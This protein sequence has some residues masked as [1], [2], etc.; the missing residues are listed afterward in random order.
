MRD[1]GRVISADSLEQQAVHRVRDRGRVT[2][3]DSLEQRAV[4]RQSERQ[5]E[6]DICRQLRTAGC[7]QTE[8]G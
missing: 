1:R 8:G 4:H 7:T 5:R 2:T 3:A 6:G